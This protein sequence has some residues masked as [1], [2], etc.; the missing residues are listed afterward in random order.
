MWQ[1]PKKNCSGKGSFPRLRPKLAPSA[2]A[3]MGTRKHSGLKTGEEANAS[4]PVFY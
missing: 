3:W 1:L 4:S 2:P